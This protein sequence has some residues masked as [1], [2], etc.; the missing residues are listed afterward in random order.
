TTCPCDADQN[1]TIDDGG[2]FLEVA[3]RY[4][5]NGPL[6]LNN[7]ASIFSVT[8]TLFGNGIN[9]SWNDVGADIY[10]VWWGDESVAAGS[11]CGATNNCTQTTGNSF[12]EV[13]PQ[14]VNDRYYLVV[15]WQ[16]GEVIAESRT[17]KSVRLTDFIYLPTI[18]R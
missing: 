7:A 18:S 9:L 12:S 6:A 10:E 2:Y 4:N 14:G 13:L 15:A 1:G 17:Y 5:Q 16:N 3:E 8:W 11:N